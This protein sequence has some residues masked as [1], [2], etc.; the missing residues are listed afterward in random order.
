MFHGYNQIY[1]DVRRKKE[2]WREYLKNL[3]FLF[4][5][6]QDLRELEAYVVTRRNNKAE[7]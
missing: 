5:T 1:W 6:L 4:S 3:I 2:K 7:G